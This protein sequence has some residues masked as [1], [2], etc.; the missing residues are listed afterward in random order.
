MEQVVHT[1]RSEWRSTH[2]VRCR[3]PLLPLHRVGCE[4]VCCLCLFVVCV[5]CFVVCLLFIVLFVFVFIVLFVFVFIVLFVFVCVCV[6][7]LE[8]TGSLKTPE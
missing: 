3:T 4:C 6:I 8:G 5:Y 7:Y 2:N 1:L